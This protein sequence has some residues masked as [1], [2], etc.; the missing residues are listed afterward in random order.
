MSSIAERIKAVKQRVEQAAVQAGRQAEDVQLIAV[1]KTKPTPDIEEAIASGQFHFGEN[2]MQELAQKMDAITHPSAQWHMIGTMQSN[3]IKYIA[4][5]VNWIHSVHK[6]K[7]LDEIEKRVPDGHHVH[8]LFQVNIS[9]ESQKSGCSPDELPR[10]LE[11]AAQ[12]S[13][14]SVHGLMGIS[15]MV[16]DPEQVRSEFSLL[17]ELFEHYREFDAPNVSLTELSMGMSADLEVAIQEGAT[18]VRV[19][20]DIFGSR[21]YA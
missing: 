4:P 20:S 15:S 6:A 9:G 10:L 18:M 5:R 2:K 13:K 11:H 14:L 17:R 3:K 7:Y 19:G 12:F 16:D 1:S 8:V 21:N